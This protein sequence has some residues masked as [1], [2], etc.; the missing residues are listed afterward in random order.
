MRVT[1]DL[2]AKRSLTPNEQRVYKLLQEGLE[3]LEVARRLH[4][5]LKISNLANRHDVP[6][7]T[8]KG[9]MASIREKGWEIPNKE[10]NNM[11]KGQKTPEEKIHEISVLRDEG[12]SQNKIAEITGVPLSTVGKICARIGKAET[13]EEPAPSANDTSSKKETIP[14]TIVPEIPADVNPCDEISDENF[15][16]EVTGDTDMEAYTAD[17]EKFLAAKGHELPTIVW[18]A[19][20]EKMEEL[21]SKIEV[22]QSDIK[23]WAC[24]ISEISAFMTGYVMHKTDEEVQ[25]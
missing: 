18:E 17:R 20:K 23:E 22:A 12:K 9:L 14:T 5:A 16:C 25:Q 13:K 1:I 7:D 21:R 11:A 4:M 2:P 19:C 6:P 10:E 24:E 3:P 8:V 15:C